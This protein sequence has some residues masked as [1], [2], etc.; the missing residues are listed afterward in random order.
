[1]NGCVLNKLCAW[2]LLVLLFIEEKR[3][4]EVMA[5]IRGDSLV[6]KTDICMGRSFNCNILQGHIY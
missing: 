5:P 4:S 2:F 1:M 3:C 6:F